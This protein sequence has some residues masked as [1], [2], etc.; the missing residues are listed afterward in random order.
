[1]K[2][3]ITDKPGVSISKGMIGLFFEDIN[4]GLDGGLHA[5]MIENRSF[6]FMKATGDRGA[7]ARATTGSMAGQHIRL[8]PAGLSF[9]FR[10]SIRR[11]RSIPIT[12]RLPP[13]RR[14]TLLPI[15]PMM[16]CP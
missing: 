15:R 14:R 9:R 5:E 13:G 12:W 7:T 11:M 3:Q 6:E 2:I 1:M 16:V 4:Y 10:R 8:R